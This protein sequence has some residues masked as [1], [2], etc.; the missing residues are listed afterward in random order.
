MERRRAAPTVRVMKTLVAGGGVAAIE[1]VLALQA[2]AGDRVEIEL[3]AP[4]GDFIVRAAFDG[5]D[6]PRVALGELGV[7]HRRGALAAVAGNV[8]R[9]TDGASHV[10]DRLV[11]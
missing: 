9:T 6:T 8:A 10:F 1:T 2:L 11:V 5:A 4:G 3:L 7:R